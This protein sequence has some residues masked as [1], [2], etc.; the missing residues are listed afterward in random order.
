MGNYAQ[1]AGADQ[2]PAALGARWGSWSPVGYRAPSCLHPQ[3]RRDLGGGEGPREIWAHGQGS[4]ASLM[5]SMVLVFLGP[6][7]GPG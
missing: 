5:S 3:N 7:V 4:G 1:R 6:A 2:D